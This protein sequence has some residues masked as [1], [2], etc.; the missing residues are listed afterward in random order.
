MFSICSP[1]NVSKFNI[2]V[3]TVSQILVP[4]LLVCKM[5]LQPII[6]CCNDHSVLYDRDNTCPLW[7]VHTFISEQQE[8]KDS[9]ESQYASLTFLTLF[10]EV[11]LWSVAKVLLIHPV[12]VG[13][14]YTSCKPVKVAKWLWEFEN[15]AKCLS[16]M[17]MENMEFM[18]QSL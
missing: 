10:R 5:S 4:I 17:W 11:A 12:P 6:Y 15:L 9:V 16:D 3:T 2:V 7:V 8:Q 1:L 18:L 14:S 13:V